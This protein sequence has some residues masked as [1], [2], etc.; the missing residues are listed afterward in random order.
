MARPP[1]SEPLSTDALS[2]PVSLG[3]YTCST[4]A[5][6]TYNG[7]WADSRP[8][9]RIQRERSRRKIVRPHAAAPRRGKAGQSEATGPNAGPAFQPHPGY[10]PILALC[11]S[12]RKSIGHGGG[13]LPGPEP[14][15]HG[16]RCGSAPGLPRRQRAYHRE[17]YGRLRSNNQPSPLSLETRPVVSALTKRNIG[18]MSTLTVKFHL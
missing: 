14:A 4:R 11:S 3:G 8:D 7:R 15:W 18:T 17:H 2:D 16:Y 10:P 6:G 9:Y 5:R 12:D 1:R 13:S